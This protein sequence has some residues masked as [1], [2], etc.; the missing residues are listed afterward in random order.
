MLISLSYFIYRFLK[1]L[2]EDIYVHKHSGHDA[3][4]SLANKGYVIYA[5]V[6][7][8]KD[9]DK[10]KGYGIPN[11]VPAIIDVTKQDTIDK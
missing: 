11:L 5:G 9:F 8:Q 4:L 2:I 7:S 10:I 1:V 6:R 3:G